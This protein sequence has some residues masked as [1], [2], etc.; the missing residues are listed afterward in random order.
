MVIYTSINRIV[1]LHGYITYNDCLILCLVEV[2][3]GYKIWHTKMG[4][5]SVLLKEQIIALTKA[6]Q[7]QRCWLYIKDCMNNCSVGSQNVNES[8]S[9]VNLEQYFI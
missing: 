2:F 5:L 6:C 1:L 8:G 4:S 9:I 7:G 3:A